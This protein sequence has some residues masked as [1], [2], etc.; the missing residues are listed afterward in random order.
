MIDFTALRLSQR[1]GLTVFGLNA[2]Q[3]FN[4]VFGGLYL[5]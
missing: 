2:H 3:L 4:Y 5:N 1:T